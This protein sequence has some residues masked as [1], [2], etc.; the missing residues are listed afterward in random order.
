MASSYQETKVRGKPK[1]EFYPKTIYF[2][3]ALPYLKQKDSFFIRN[4]GGEYSKIM[5]STPPQ[6]IKIIRTK[7]LYPDSKFPMKVDI[8][9]VAIR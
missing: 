6:W 2:D 3:K 7:S 1:L 9:A 8:E 4:V 5:I